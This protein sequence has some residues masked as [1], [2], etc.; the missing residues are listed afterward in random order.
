[1][2]LIT[3]LD[4]NGFTWQKASGVSGSLFK[5]WISKKQDTADDSYVK[6]VYRTVKEIFKTDEELK[7][8]V[9]HCKFVVCY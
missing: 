5:I 2:F 8:V 6:N 4:I 9:T 1:M 3:H 7:E